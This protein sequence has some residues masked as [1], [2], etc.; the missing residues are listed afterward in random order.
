MGANSSIP[1]DIQSAIVNAVSD[2]PEGASLDEIAAVLPGAPNRAAVQQWILAMYLRGAVRMDQSV[3]PARYRVA[4][5]QAPE[6]PKSDLPVS[7]IDGPGATNSSMSPPVHEDPVPGI[8]KENADASASLLDN[9]VGSI[10]EAAI[11][12][13]ERSASA[14]SAANQN[15]TPAFNK[16]ATA[17]QSLRT[18]NGSDAAT[19]QELSKRAID[20]LTGFFA[21]ALQD[22]ARGKLSPQ[23]ATLAV[24]AFVLVS[25]VLGPYLQRSSLLMSLLPILTIVGVFVWRALKVPQNTADKYPKA[26]AQ[27]TTTS[28]SNTPPEIRKQGYR[29]TFWLLVIILVAVIGIGGGIYVY[30]DITSHPS[31]SDLRTHLVTL[32]APLPVQVTGLEITAIIPGKLRCELTYAARIETT[33]VLYRR[34][35]PIDYLRTHAPKELA[36]INSAAELLQGPN[37]DQLR[38]EAATPSA[39]AQSTTNDLLN[40]QD[41]PLFAVQAAPGLAVHVSGAVTAWR[42]D[43]KWEF[44]DDRGA[45]QRTQFVGE[46]IPVG[47]PR[48]VVEQAV[49]AAKLSTVLAQKMA[50][51]ERIQVAAVSHQQMRNKG[52]ATARIGDAHAPQVSSTEVP[53]VPVAAMPPQTHKSLPPSTNVPVVVAVA[54]TPNPEPPKFNAAPKTSEDGGQQSD[55]KST[56]GTSLR[57][58]AATPSQSSEDKGQ[59]PDS[60]PSANVGGAPAATTSQTSEDRNQ[61]SD[62]VGGVPAA[63][64]A[65]M[66]SEDRGQQSDLKGRAGTPLPAGSAA[67]SPVPGL[68]SVGPAKEGPL[69]PEPPLPTQEGAYIRV[70]SGWVPLP[71]SH[72]YVVKST[73]RGVAGILSKV[74][75]AQDTLAGKTSDAA[76]PLYGN[77]TFDRQDSLPV[78]TGDNV[79]IVYI[80]PLTPITSEQL[81]RNPELQNYPVMELAP[82]KTDQHGYR[83]APLYEIAPGVIAFAQGRVPATI[84]LTER[85]ALIFRCTGLLASGR[86]A[87]SCGPKC[88]EVIVR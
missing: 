32:L 24:S 80:G 88:Y 6:S 45:P 64:A 2:R 55:S 68:P 81:A 36:A 67:T 58:A 79:V 1:P 38:T 62:T 69:S 41:L 7:A 22:F 76:A 74:Q 17:T 60:T 40:V 56:A 53:P 57:T 10:L 48:F 34:V 39:G 37:G 9:A 31:K 72:N 47:A 59:R 83:Y 84:E 21:A 50:Y 51:A 20:G 12:E 42:H 4:P 19:K 66:T 18:P 77:L 16:P 54:P 14:A 82:M 86:Y 28:A 52:Q 78:V 13:L 26:L 63:A 75:H 61:R 35:D 33:E 11:G 44:T 49:D 30:R 85:S 15:G 23:L 87:L 70:A 8:S 3:T 43:G 5:R 27:N 71:R 65:A 29:R 46:I 25:S 73:A